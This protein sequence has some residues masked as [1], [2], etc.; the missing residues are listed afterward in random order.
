M[1]RTSHPH[2]TTNARQTQ[3]VHHAS[4]DTTATKATYDPTA[5]LHSNADTSELWEVLGKDYTKL[6]LTFNQI[7]SWGMRFQAASQT[8]EWNLANHPNMFKQTYRTKSFT[9]SF[10]Q[11]LYP[12]P[13][14]QN[15]VSSSRK[16]PRRKCSQLKPDI[17]CAEL[18]DA[19]Q[20]TLP[21]ITT[22][23]R[24]ILGH[25]QSGQQLLPQV[26]HK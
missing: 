22:R 7:R 26:I 9:P 2:S 8:S 16:K 20:I 17:S 21:Q 13:D 11:P 24:H 6:L 23:E 15:D 5:N 25:P 10:E 18:K 19:P 1:P 3:H 4:K 14:Q 12:P